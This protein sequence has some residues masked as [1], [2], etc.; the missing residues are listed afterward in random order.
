MAAKDV[1]LACFACSAQAPCGEWAKKYFQEEPIVL[2][3]P[4][5]GGPDFRTKVLTWAQTGDIFTAALKELKP[6]L[7]ETSIRRRGLVTFSVGWSAADELLKFESERKKLDAY[8]L[9][10]GCH[11]QSLDHWKAFAVRAANLEATMIMAH[12][13][14]KPEFISSQVSNTMLFDYAAKINNQTSG[15]PRVESILPSYL[16]DLELEKPI[17]IS[18]GAAGTLPPIKKTW[19]HDPLLGY[20]NRGNLTRLHYSGGDRPDHVYIAWY[21]SQRLWQYLGELWHD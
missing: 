19:L 13:S 3:I 1:I 6:A 16:I 18:L 9:L 20:Y 17:E 8:L 2:N 15:V 11:T 5:A 10:D 14:I 21:V 7:A 4:G 12:S